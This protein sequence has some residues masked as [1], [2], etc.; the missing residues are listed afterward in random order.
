MVIQ[1]SVVIIISL[2]IIIIIRYLSYFFYQGRFSPI[3]G[4]SLP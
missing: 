1:F 4:I 2:I 3:L